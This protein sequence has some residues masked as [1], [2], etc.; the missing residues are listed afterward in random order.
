MQCVNVRNMH[1][2]TERSQ[3]LTVVLPVYAQGRVGKTL[4]SLL[5]H[6]RYVLLT[7][8]I[9]IDKQG[10]AILEATQF[11]H[12]PGRVQQAKDYITELEE[13][14]EILGALERPILDLHYAG[15][16]ITPKDPDNDTSQEWPT[17]TT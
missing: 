2:K 12:L 5:R 6:T 16:D 3:H 17:S 13:R 15:G 7:G 1:E 4:L 10:R 11:T 8:Y 9:S 14:G